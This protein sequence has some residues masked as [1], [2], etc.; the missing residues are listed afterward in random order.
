MNGAT[1]LKGISG[2][3]VRFFGMVMGA[4]IFAIGLCWLPPYI[5]PCSAAQKARA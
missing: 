1:W 4:D 5:G 2:L 3:L